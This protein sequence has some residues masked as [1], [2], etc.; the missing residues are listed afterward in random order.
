MSEE[1][2][3]K[4]LASNSKISESEKNMS[5]S[6]SMSATLKPQKPSYHELLAKHHGYIAPRKK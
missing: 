6:R 1:V 4:L 3:A 5:M 2:Y